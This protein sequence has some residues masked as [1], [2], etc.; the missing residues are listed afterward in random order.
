MYIH[1]YIYII[2]IYIYITFCFLL[3]FV[4]LFDLSAVRFCMCLFY[5]NTSVEKILNV[6]YVFT[7][8]NSTHCKLSNNCT[9]IL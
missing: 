4:D 9:E 6:I 3:A 5:L 7:Q 8:Y 2:Y 1:I